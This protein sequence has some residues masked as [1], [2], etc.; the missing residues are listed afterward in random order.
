MQYALFIPKFINWLEGFINYM[1][2]SYFKYVLE[3]KI[4]NITV[5]LIG[6]R[7]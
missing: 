7:L 6:Y 2:Y 5:L 4:K 1:G 3:V